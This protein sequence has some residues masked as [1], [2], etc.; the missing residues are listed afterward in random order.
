MSAFSEYRANEDVFDA[1]V[2]QGVA[3]SWAPAPALNVRAR[4][5]HVQPIAASFARSTAAGLGA[6]WEP[7]DRRQLVSGDVEYGVANNGVQ[8]WYVS[9]AL[10][11]RWEDVTLLSRARLAASTGEGQGR[12]RARARLGW[13][14][15]P[16]E[17][18]ALNTLAWYEFD[19]DDTPGLREVR[20]SWTIGG[21]RK[22]DEPLRLRGRLAG[23]YYSQTNVTAGLELD[24]VL[25]MVQG[26][27]ERDMGERWMLGA[28][29]AAFTD[30]RFEDQTFAFGAEVGF[31]PARNTLIGLGYNHS[32]LEQSRVERLYRTGWFIRLQLQIDEDVWN[33]FQ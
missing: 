11:R 31:V 16:P 28:N 22:I 21:E 10:G 32:V 30:G 1:G 18:D 33:I 20:H 24:R 27:A 14:H 12:T 3:A 5:E 7:E 17:N 8:S 6:T 25:M 19:V 23:Q 4:L 29:M 26:G 13:A 2:A 15:R 9:G